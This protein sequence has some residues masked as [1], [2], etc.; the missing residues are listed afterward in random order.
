M[1]TVSDIFFE[2][3]KTLNYLLYHPIS[4]NL[5]AP[6]SP[7]RMRHVVMENSFI[8]NDILCISGP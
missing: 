6:D 5:I 1:L 3:N 7:Q 2:I 4:V 8:E